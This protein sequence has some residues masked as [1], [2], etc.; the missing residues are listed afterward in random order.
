[1]CYVYL[2]YYLCDLMNLY[3]FFWAMRPPLLF[4]NRRHFLQSIPYWRK[5]IIACPFMSPSLRRHSFIVIILFQLITNQCLNSIAVQI[6]IAVLMTSPNWLNVF[7]EALGWYIIIQVWLLLLLIY[8][9]FYWYIG[10]RL[11]YFRKK[12]IWT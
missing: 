1:M 9:Y 7:T 2:L 6:I 4:Y 10:N 11:F 12:H 8:C 5:N 3:F